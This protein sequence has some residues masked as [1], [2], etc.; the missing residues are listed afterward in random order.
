MKILIQVCFALLVVGGLAACKDE[1]AE[2]AKLLYERAELYSE[3]R[4]FS[5]AIEILQRIQIDYGE[6]EYGP[7]SEQM[8]E[9]FQRLQDLVL[10]ND[11]DEIR[12][13]FSRINRALDNYRVRFLAY[14]ITPEDMKKLPAVVNPEWIDPWGNPIY[15]KPTYSSER[16]P[17]RA[18]DGFVLGSFGKDGLPGGTGQDLDLFYRDNKEIESIFEE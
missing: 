10:K 12:S 8:I 7:R 14:P 4:Q 3:R 11:R 17:R 16:I 2:K 9:E 6:T 15:Y 5:Q 13:K 1:K 18:P